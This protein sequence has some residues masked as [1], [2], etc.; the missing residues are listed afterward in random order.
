MIDIKKITDIINDE[1]QQDVKKSEIEALCF[2]LIHLSIKILGL[3][4]SDQQIEKLIE[5]AK[6][7]EHG[8]EIKL[9]ETH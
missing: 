7:L 1:I 6:N 9:N 3:F 2:T 4:L 8:A 5:D